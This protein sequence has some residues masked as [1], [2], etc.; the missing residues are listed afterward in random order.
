MPKKNRP[1]NLQLPEDFREDDLSFMVHEVNGAFLREALRFAVPITRIHQHP[2]TRGLCHSFREILPHGE[3]AQTFVE[4]HNRGI[5]PTPCC[6]IAQGFQPLAIYREELEFRGYRELK[7][8]KNHLE[9]RSSK[10]QI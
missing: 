4:H 9:N 2:A 5:R 3:G 1:L 6:C 8:R 7:S 10:S